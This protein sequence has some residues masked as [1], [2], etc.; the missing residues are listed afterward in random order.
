MIGGPHGA[1]PSWKCGAEE[2][3]ACLFITSAPLSAVPSLLPAPPHNTPGTLRS[4]PPTAPPYSNQPPPR[5]HH[6]PVLE[7][8]ELW[9]L[10]YVLF[11]SGGAVL[12]GLLMEVGTVGRDRRVDSDRAALAA[13]PAGHLPPR[14][15]RSAEPAAEGLPPGRRGFAFDDGDN[16]TAH[17]GQQPQPK[18]RLF[19]FLFNFHVTA[20]QMASKEKGLENGRIK[21]S[22]KG[23]SNPGRASLAWLGFTGYNPSP[24]PH[25]PG[26]AS[27][28]RLHY[29]VQL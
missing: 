24:L 9:L 10:V 15:R 27:L 23:G 18:C 29:P 22:R 6:K 13:P 4:N 21:R 12:V 7:P 8:G 26:R 2:E 16:K 17:V 20:K 25:K 28:A 14:R 1:L 5:R 3:L 19:C 11:L